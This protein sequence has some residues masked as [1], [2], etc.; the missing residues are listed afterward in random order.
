[1]ASLIR[2]ITQSFS[3][4]KLILALSKKQF[5]KNKQSKFSEGRKKLK[6]EESK[7]KIQEYYEK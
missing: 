6:K 3:F 4:L 7:V 1:V 5:T 2:P